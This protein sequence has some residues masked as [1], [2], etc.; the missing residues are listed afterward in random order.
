MFEIKQHH[1]WQFVFMVKKDYS[2]MASGG[3][4]T[5]GWYAA[6]V[7]VCRFTG[8][9]EEGSPIAATPHEGFLTSF[10]FWLPFYR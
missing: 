1:E 10:R 6:L 5:L 3:S 8:E 2:Y 7:G 4:P 9:F